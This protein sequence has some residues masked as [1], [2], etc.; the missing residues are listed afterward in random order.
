MA[1]KGKKIITKFR[2]PLPF[3]IGTVLFGLVLLYLLSCV[4]LYFVR[5]RVTVY[6][7]ETGEIME[8]G[9]YTGLAL[10]TEQVVNA[11]A[12][13][14]V[15]YIAPEGTKTGLNTYVY[16]LSPNADNDLLEGL[17]ADLDEDNYRALYEEITGFE[18]S[19]DPSLF[20]DT[21]SFKSTLE[22]SIY[23]EIRTSLLEKEER[24]ITAIADIRK[25]PVS[26]VVVYNVDGLEGV[27]YQNLTKDMFS[28][29]N[30]TKTELRAK[31]RL[32]AGEPAYKLVTDEEWELVIRLDPSEVKH[33]VDDEYVQV[34]FMRD[35][36]I[37]WAQVEKFKI[38]DDDYCR[39]KF[40]NSMIR[41]A[42]DRFLQVEVI[43]N[44]VSGLK[45]P[46]SSIVVKKFF[47]IPVD[48][49]TDIS[50]GQATVMALN[51]TETGNETVPM[52]FNIYERTA[53]AVYVDMGDIKEGTVLVNP[54]DS[55]STYAVGTVGELHGVYDI[56]RGYADFNLVTVLY[57][58]DEYCIVKSD[59]AYGLS[60]YDRIVLDGSKVND[61]QQVYQ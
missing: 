48:F 60:I 29:A 17:G 14:Y 18:S 38:D 15:T 52:T 53:D 2:R 20:S 11:D 34:K 57:N 19:F 32:E 39:L 46:N 5:D 27:A 51:S 59:D 26:G 43:I 6:Q 28:R 30:Y 56:N 13:G 40:T 16:G 3:H 33:F 58:N 8:N 50:D 12:G 36:N 7:V 25:S 54:K 49:T 37:V 31:D 9:Q 4:V 44:S 1:G 42:T 45:V 22:G 35:Q 10:R 41:Y 47:T 23:D 24:D 55:K 21:Y 61:E